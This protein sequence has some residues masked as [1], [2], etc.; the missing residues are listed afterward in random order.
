MKRLLP[1]LLLLLLADLAQ[2][3][4]APLEVRRK[5]AAAAE[6]QVGVTLVYDPAYVRLAYPG[7]DL[8]MARGVCA[9][10]I[11]RALRTIGVDLQREVHVDMKANFS[12]YPQ[13]WQLRGT[14]RNIDHRRVPNLM[15]FFERHGKRLARG[16][17]HEAGDIVAWSLP[18]GLHHIGIVTADRVPRSARPL[19]VHNIG[20]GAQKEDILNA[21][22][23]LG[24][25]RW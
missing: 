3:S 25:Y 21:W 22:P 12:K 19:I 1:L 20:R 6:K 10:V 8:P 23:I 7:G 15:R 14:D 24:H 4:H 18:G 13:L 16:T 2:A 11:I 17:S 5:I 9:D